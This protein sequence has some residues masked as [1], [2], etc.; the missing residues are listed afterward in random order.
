MMKK[1]IRCFATTVL[2]F[3]FVQQAGAWTTV[4]DPTNFVKNTITAA[5]AVK[6]EVYQTPT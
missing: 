6:G 3:G 2:T 5:A 1:L 4:F